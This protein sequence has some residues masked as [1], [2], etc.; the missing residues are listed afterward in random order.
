MQTAENAPVI[1]TRK[2]KLTYDDYAALTPPDSGNYELHNGKIVFMA[3]PTPRHQD[4][5]TELS[6]RMRIF[7]ST[8]KLGKVYTAPLDTVFASFD[9]FQPDILFI[10]KARLNII[11]DK[12]VEGAPDLVVEVLSEGN[13]PMEM[14]YKKYIYES[15]L[16]QEYWLV[17][18]KKNTVTVYQNMEGELMPVGIFSGN[19]QVNSQVLPGFQISVAEILQ[20][21]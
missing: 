14:S 17:N 18:L 20:E 13:K 9:T 2:K 16:V 3:S 5:V 8:Q 10:A 1:K 12:K 21:S 6:A 15:H 7:A 19:D 4:I 11:G